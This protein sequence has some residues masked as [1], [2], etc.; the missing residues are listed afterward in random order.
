MGSKT[1]IAGHGVFESIGLLIG[2]VH[3]KKLR[4]TTSTN[5]PRQKPSILYSETHFN[6][7]TSHS[8]RGNHTMNPSIFKYMLPSLL[9]KNSVYP[10]F[11]LRRPNLLQITSGT[12]SL[13]LNRFASVSRRIIMQNSS[14]FDN[15][16]SRRDT[17]GASDFFLFTPV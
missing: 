17:S 15:K 6:S 16:L 11:L 5:T 3:I 14:V 4:C 1:R 8:L 13:I 7:S 10:S 9:K 12:V 2:H